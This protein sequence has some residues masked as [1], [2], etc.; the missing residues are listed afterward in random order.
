M[1]FTSLVKSEAAFMIA[2]ALRILLKKQI[3]SSRDNPAVIKRIY[4]KASSNC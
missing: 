1:L 4:P 3:N 2:M